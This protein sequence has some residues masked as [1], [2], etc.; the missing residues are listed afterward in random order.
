MAKIVSILGYF[1]RKRRGKWVIIPP[2]WV[3]HTRFKSRCCTGYFP[4]P[5][6][7][8]REKTNFRL[9]QREILAEVLDAAEDRHYTICTEKNNEFQ[10]QC[11][12]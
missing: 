8:V 4:L 11:T 10:E 2:H 6:K 3:G 7:L 1:Y 9:L 5:R 12:T